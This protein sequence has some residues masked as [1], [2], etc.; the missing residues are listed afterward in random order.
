MKGASGSKG[1]DAMTIIAV[2]LKR[3]LWGSLLQGIFR[4]AVALPG[5]VRD[6]MKGSRVIFKRDAL[7]LLDRD[8]GL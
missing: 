3:D 8:R 2:E 1:S 7:A 4:K 6:N 5:A